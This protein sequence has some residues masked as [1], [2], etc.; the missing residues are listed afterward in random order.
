M[1]KR[2]GHAPEMARF[3]RYV[4]ARDDRDLPGEEI[5]LWLGTGGPVLETIV[6]DD[7]EAELSAHGSEVARLHR[8][9]PSPEDPDFAGEETDFSLRSDGYVL[10]RRVFRWRDGDPD[11]D[12]WRLHSRIKA[13]TTAER[14]E[15]IPV[16]FP[17]VIR[18]LTG[19]GFTL[20]EGPAAVEVRDELTGGD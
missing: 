2:S 19:K 4:P 7:I 18:H 15:R 1:G 6:Q 13:A 12:S 5:D 20:R 3:H 10:V 17:K 8:H 16:V 9:V 14:R 11:R